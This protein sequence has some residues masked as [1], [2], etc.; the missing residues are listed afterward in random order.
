LEGGYET[1]DPGTL[2]KRYDEILA[3]PGFSSIDAV[4]NNNVFISTYIDL[5]GPDFILV[6]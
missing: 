5:L 1:N 6:L 3:K 2:K 4:K